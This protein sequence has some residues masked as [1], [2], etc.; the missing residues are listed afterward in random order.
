MP[1]QAGIGAPVST[2]KAGT[3]FSRCLHSGAGPPCNPR[4]KSPKVAR[5]RPARTAEVA[6]DDLE[7]ERALTAELE[8]E[9]QIGG[10]GKIRE[11]F[12]G[13]QSYLYDASA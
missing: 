8:A 11:A 3:D 4:P 1:L 10:V 9:R 7:Q 2:E 12:I 6:P 13:F 5:P